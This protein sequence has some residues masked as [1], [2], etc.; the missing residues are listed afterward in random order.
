MGLSRQERRELAKI[1]RFL[2][3]SDPVLAAMFRDGRPLRPLVVHRIA[4]NISLGFAVG[5]A[6]AGVV[7]LSMTLV[8]LGVVLLPTVAILGWI[9][10]SGR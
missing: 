4:D 10:L 8:L 1:E 6:V 3:D 2:V 7:V 9:I 5:L